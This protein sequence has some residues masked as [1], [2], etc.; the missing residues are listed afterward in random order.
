[1]TENKDILKFVATHN[2]RP[3]VVVGFAAETQNLKNNAKLKLKSKKCD[4]IV[5]N[6]VATGK[7]NIGSN[8]NSVHIYNNS[9]CLAKYN[10]MDKNLL[11]SKMLIEIIY[12][13]LAKS[14]LSTSSHKEDANTQN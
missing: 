14:K 3:R 12:P 2:K 5:A 7:K 6:N 13:I 1:M 11:S 10:E 4:L 8:K 9:R